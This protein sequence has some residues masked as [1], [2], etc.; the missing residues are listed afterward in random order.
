M[1]ELNHNIQTAYNLGMESLKSAPKVLD[2]IPFVVLPEG[3]KVHKFEEV[4]DRPL[5]LQQ[6]VNLHTAKDLISYVN[7]FADDNSVIFFDVMAG[8]V[9]AILDYH[10]AIPVAGY[11]SNALQRN[12]NH[13]A[14]FTV[15]KTSEFKKI[16]ENSGKKFSQQ[17][18]A[19]FLED[20]VPYINQPDATVLLEI[21][22]T[23][24]AK[25]NVDFKSGIRTDNGQ[26]QLTYNE[27]I[28]ARAGVTGNLSIPEKLVFGIQVHRGGSHYALPARFRYRI[29][30]GVITFWYDLDQLEKAIEKSMEDTIDYI[31]NGK[32]VVD[33]I[34][35]QEV[36]TNLPGVNPTVTILEGSA[37]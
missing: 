30:D 6:V 4:L 18:F 32:Q 34:D 8:R 26:V 21:V 22:Q 16:E 23:L 24:N 36:T 10:E 11:N 12:C 14:N 33:V 2:A 28:E 1:T 27:T 29:K 9:K 35:D 31:R 3:S 20:V 15:D 19:L 25:T 5:N 13:V 7:R 37:S 17:D